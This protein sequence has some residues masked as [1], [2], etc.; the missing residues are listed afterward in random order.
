MSAPAE[1]SKAQPERQQQP[2]M[3]LLTDVAMHWMRCMIDK[4]FPPL[5]PHHTQALVVMMM[6]R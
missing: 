3:L 5:T 6:A 4:N 2:E 1:Q